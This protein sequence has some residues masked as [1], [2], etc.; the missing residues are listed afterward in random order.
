M[1]GCPR[2]HIVQVISQENDTEELSATM[3]PGLAKYSLRDKR[4]AFSREHREI[5]V[6]TGEK[7]NKNGDSII[8]KK[9]VLK[10]L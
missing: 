9:L 8:L 10:H 4:Y 6:P 2:V 3:T 5:L 7:F 1:R